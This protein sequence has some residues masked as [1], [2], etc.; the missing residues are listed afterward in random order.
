M[1]LISRCPSGY[2]GPQCELSATLFIMAS[3]GLVMSS[4]A[5]LGLVVYGISRLASCAFLN[6][7]TTGPPIQGIR[8]RRGLF[9]GQGTLGDLL[10]E[11]ETSFRARPAL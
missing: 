8:L 4:L 2:S 1:F 3:V 10:E 11:K 6:V 9:S 7:A 5:L